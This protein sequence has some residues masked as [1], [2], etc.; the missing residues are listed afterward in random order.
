MVGIGDKNLKPV[1][2]L[3]IKWS[4]RYATKPAQLKSLVKFC[5]ENALKQALVTTITIQAVVE[6]EGIEFTF[7]PAAAYAYTIGANT[8]HANLEYP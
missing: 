6:Y 3:E 5:K 2:A 8:L 4:D 7:I 1:W